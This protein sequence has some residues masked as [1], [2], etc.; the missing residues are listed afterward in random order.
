MREMTTEQVALA[1]ACVKAGI[2]LLGGESRDGFE[3]ASVER[4]QLTSVLARAQAATA[5]YEALRLAQTEAGEIIESLLRQLTVRGVPLE[6]TTARY[7]FM[8]EAM[9]KAIA[10]YEKVVKG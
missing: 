6:H 10:D 7:G 9:R 4:R 5:L 1:D 3:I 2:N 8:Q